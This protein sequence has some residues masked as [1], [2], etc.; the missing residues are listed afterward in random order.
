[1]GSSPRSTTCCVHFCKIQ[2]DAATMDT[3]SMPPWTHCGSFTLETFSSSF[4]CSS[5][6][7]LPPLYRL[8]SSDS[9]D[10][11]VE[12]LKEP[13]RGPHALRC[14]QEHLPS[15]MPPPLPPQVNAHS[16]KS[17]AG[18]GSYASDVEYVRSLRESFACLRG[19]MVVT[20][21]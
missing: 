16:L 12:G 5:I 21:A 9:C 3:L 19:C 2:S 1:M 11:L 6:G 8:L 14:F 10:Y 15:R 20:N 18:R 4:A 17:Q 13:C 7:A